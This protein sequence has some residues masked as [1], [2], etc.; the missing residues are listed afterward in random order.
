MAAIASPAPPAARAR[1]PQ[2]SLGWAASSAS[3]PEPLGIDSEHVDERLRGGV[4]AS[5]PRSS[6]AA[7]LLAEAPASTAVVTPK[8]PA[9]S[10]MVD[11]SDNL[12]TACHAQQ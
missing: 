2:P 12:S 4:D 9:R 8:M 3:M 1:P 11:S 5:A 6:A 10:E 7:P